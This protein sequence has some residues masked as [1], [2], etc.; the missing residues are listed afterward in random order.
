MTPGE[1]ADWKQH[2]VTKAWQR[3]LLEEVEDVRQ[4]TTLYFPDSIDKTALTGANMAGLLDGIDMALNLE[5]E[6]EV[7][8]S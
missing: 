2:P 3:M 7:D 8:E 1:W 4:N 6:F 5:P